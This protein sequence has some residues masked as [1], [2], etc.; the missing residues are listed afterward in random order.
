MQDEDDVSMGIRPLI[1]HE[2]VDIAKVDALG[3]DRR[4]IS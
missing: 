3:L 4:L 2:K 1:M